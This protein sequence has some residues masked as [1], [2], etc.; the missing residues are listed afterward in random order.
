[1]VHTFGHPFAAAGVKL[2]GCGGGGG[3]GGVG[4]RAFPGFIAKV[5]IAFRLVS[6][7]VFFEDVH[8]CRKPELPDG[9][10]HG[11]GAFSQ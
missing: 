1:L 5:S 3:G 10:A 11:S 2:E 8:S 9:F 7:K 6:K 4:G